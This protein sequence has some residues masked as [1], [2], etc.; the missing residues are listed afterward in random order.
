LPVSAAERIESGWWD[1]ADVARDYHTA[2]R[3]DGLTCWI[4]RD[5]RSPGQWYL[6]GIFA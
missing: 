1:G 6:H 3:A 2:E 4:Y 5:L